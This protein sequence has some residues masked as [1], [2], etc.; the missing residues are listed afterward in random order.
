LT[1]GAVSVPVKRLVGRLGGRNEP[2]TYWI[3]VGAETVTGNIGQRL[4][5]LRY[6]IAGEVPD[7]L[8]FRVSSIGG[9]A[10]AAYRLHDSFISSLL[11]SVD[12]QTV[13]RLAG[14][15]RTDA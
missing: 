14:K 13:E 6:G 15:S 12:A 2:I 4:V 9:D 5:Q 11:A 8:I 10:E 3:R 7:G 1:F